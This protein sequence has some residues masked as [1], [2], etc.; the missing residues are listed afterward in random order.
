MTSR[1][2]SM[3][4]HP[5]EEAPPSRTLPGRLR[6]AWA[7]AQRRHLPALLSVVLLAL[8]LIA[9]R[10]LLKD[11]LHAQEGL[12]DSLGDLK[13]TVG[14]ELGAAKVALEDTRILE[15]DIRL[16]LDA[17][18]GKE[19]SDVPVLAR[20]LQQELDAGI[21]R[22]RDVMT[23]LGGPG[24]R[25]AGTRTG[26]DRS[27]QAQLEQLAADLADARRLAVDLEQR[28]QRADQALGGAPDGGGA[29][30]PDVRAQAARIAQKLSQAE[31]V[32][33]SREASPADGGSVV[34]ARAPAGPGQDGTF[35]PL[36]ARARE[37]S[38]ALDRSSARLFGDAGQAEL[39]DLPARLR[40]VQ[41]RLQA[42]EARLDKL[43]EVLR[44]QETAVR[45]KTGSADAGSQ[46]PKPA[47]AE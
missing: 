23:Y 27:V 3:A 25:R 13:H 33:F 5:P 18:H 20:E 28:A 21:G 10:K 19:L 36:Y 16:R 34:L 22:A 11:V 7:W 26:D 47:P 4:P 12:R 46:D 44:A 40:H 29:D 24:G 38:L 17:L 41:A 30:F 14:D 43:E 42:F 45:G 37:L 35:P 32:M 8:L 31:A 2:N 39:P 1:D 15:Q 9:E 6:E